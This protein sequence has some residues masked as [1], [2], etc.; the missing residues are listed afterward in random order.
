MFHR[1]LPRRGDVDLELVADAYRFRPD[2]RREGDR[3]GRTNERGDRQ[4]PEHFGFLRRFV[5][6]DTHDRPRARC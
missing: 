1:R 3:G 5:C 4:A 2:L 6:L